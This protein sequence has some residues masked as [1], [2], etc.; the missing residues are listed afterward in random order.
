MPGA[1]S[2]TP[3]PR[4][5]WCAL[6]PLGLATLCLLPALTTGYWAEDAYW[7]CVPGELQVTG[8]TLAAKT[9]AQIRTSLHQGR[10]YPITPVL[11]TTVFWFARGVVAYK[12]FLVAGV[13]LD[14]FLFYLLIRRLSGSSGFA[15]TASCLTVGL[16]QFRVFID[17]ILAYYG[18]MQLVIAMT[19]LS[20]L[21]L[22]LYLDEGRHAWLIV[23]AGS[24]LIATL[25]YESAY[26]LVL[27]HLLMIWVS[28]TVR[29]RRLRTAAPFL[30]AV[31]ACLLTTLL[32]RRLYPLPDHYIHQLDYD[33]AAYLLG[34]AYQTSAALPLSYFGRNSLG[35]FPDIRDCR[36]VFLWT[37]GTRA[38]LVA[39]VALASGLVGLR[40][41]SQ[42]GDRLSGRWRLL[43]GT[44]L[45]LAVLPATLVCLSPDHRRA[46]EFGR[47]WIP[48]LLQYYGVGLVLATGLWLV[49]G[50]WGS[51]GGQFAPWKRVS[52]AL[53]IAALTGV[54]YRVNC[55]VAACFNAPP[56]TR[57][58]NYWTEAHIACWH[59]HR[60]NLEASLQAGLME[61]VPPRSLIQPMNPYLPW[62]ETGNIY[63]A[64]FYAMHTGKVFSVAVPSSL[65][66]DAPGPPV[67]RIRD[68]AL[69][70]SAG[71]VVLSQLG[72][73]GVGQGAAAPEQALRL[74]VRHPL[75][76]HA[77]LEP[78]FLLVGSESGRVSDGAGADAPH[79]LRSSHELRR[80]RSG[81]DWAL[82]SLRPGVDRIEPGSLKLEF[83]PVRIA[84]LLRSSDSGPATTQKPAT[85]MR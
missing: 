61:E 47:G 39:L 50:H 60:C 7:S 1:S 32:M 49:L 33:P 85:L 2:T 3:L 53:L 28:S 54:T 48:V 44:G 23:A 38:P 12:T 46:F 27:I 70:R 21:A 52:M 41:G 40:Q 35:L 56:G 15:S 62:N 57:R 72:A 75:L 5:D 14:L 4:V 73:R 22:Q 59:H 16:F 74:F 43:I 10:F 84:R 17:P 66:A 78:P 18:Q 82:F 26:P 6:C 13:V 36:A 67:Y 11:Q 34:L 30:G 9:L 65:A 64:Y 69:S 29:G 77:G 24:Y 63:S 71:W 80:L 81:R 37:I 20:L 83:N 8:T 31:V 68:V 51:M 45:M 55:E 25:T 76:Y 42:T 19:F 79:Y 58:Q